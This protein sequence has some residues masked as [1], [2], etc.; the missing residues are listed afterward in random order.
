MLKE[1]ILFSHL[2]WNAAGTAFKG[3][4]SVTLWLQ[5]LCP[6]T[7]PPSLLYD[8][9]KSGLLSMLNIGSALSLSTLA[10]RNRHVPCFLPPFSYIL[11]TCLL[12][13]SSASLSPPVPTES[14]IFRRLLTCGSVTPG[15]G[16]GR[17]WAVSLLWQSVGV[18]CLTSGFSSF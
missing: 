18:L 13:I 4:L 15:W 1:H 14:G 9:M 10:P 17:Q 16:E 6:L 8:H 7:F 12:N 11:V 3:G 2:V 5:C